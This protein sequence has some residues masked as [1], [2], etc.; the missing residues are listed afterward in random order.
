MIAES[1]FPAEWRETELK[2]ELCG[3]SQFSHAELPWHVCMVEEKHNSDSKSDFENIHTDE[4]NSKTARTKIKELISSLYV[5]QED[6]CK[7]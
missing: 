7:C 6:L 5:F 3:L 4:W 2:V 1:L